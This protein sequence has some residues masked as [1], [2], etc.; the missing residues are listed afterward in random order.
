MLSAT[1]CVKELSTAHILASLAEVML[2]I[3]ACKV[4]V[5]PCSA[6]YQVL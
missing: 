4:D 5:Y 6:L 1:E 3:S 2:H